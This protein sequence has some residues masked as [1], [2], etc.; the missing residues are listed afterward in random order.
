MSGSILLGDS[1][2]KG[3][4]T[5]K[6]KSG[7]VDRRLNMGSGVLDDE[8]VTTHNLKYVNPWMMIVT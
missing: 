6:A 1:P 5:K 8:S 3:K 7:K 2:T 4:S